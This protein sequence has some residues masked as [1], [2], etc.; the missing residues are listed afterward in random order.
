MAWPLSPP[1][2]ML[3]LR[4]EVL[5]LNCN[6]ATSSHGAAV[7]EVMPVLSY[8]SPVLSKAAAGRFNQSVILRSSPAAI[9]RWWV[10]AV[11]ECDNRNSKRTK[12]A[13]VYSC[14]V[15][16][17]FFSMN[18]LRRKRLFT[19]KTKKQIKKTPLQQK[20][21]TLNVLFFCEHLVVGEE[22]FKAFQSRSSWIPVTALLSG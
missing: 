12:A 1:K 3:P 17:D 18:Q 6:K 15:R 19:K 21:K 5:V 7:M 20:K 22:D 16:F 8:L 9:S 11:S 4:T 2:R 14:L 13:P 10:F